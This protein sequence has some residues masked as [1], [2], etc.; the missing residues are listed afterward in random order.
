MTASVPAITWPINF[1]LQSGNPLCQGIASSA[2]LDSAQLIQGD[3]RLLQIYFLLAAATQGGAATNVQL[4]AG[5]TLTVAGKLA[6]DLEATTILFEATGFT[7]LQDANSLYFD[8]AFLDLDTDEIA[9]AFTAA[10]DGQNT[11]ACLVDIIVNVPAQAAA[12]GL[13]A[14]PAS[15][16]TFQFAV[17][18]KHQVYSGDESTPTPATPTYPAA[19]AVATA[20]AQA[21]A[22]ATAIAALGTAASADTGTAAGDVVALQNVGGVAKLPAVDGSQL[23]NLPGSGSSI[24]LYP[25]LTGLILTGYSSGNV[26]FTQAAAPYGGQATYLLGGSP[27]TVQ[28]ASFAYGAYSENYIVDGTAMTSDSGPSFTLDS[29]AGLTIQNFAAATYLGLSVSEGPWTVFGGVSGN[30]FSITGCPLLSYIYA[31][32]N[33]A[34]VPVTYDP[35]TLGLIIQAAAANAQAA[36]TA[37]SAQGLDG[38]LDVTGCGTPPT[39]SATSAALAALSTLGW[40]VAHD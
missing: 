12:G 24:G 23:T 3:Q 19:A 18:L 36:N 9:A 25:G 5:A 13:P 7:Q 35:M 32:N 6:S 21:A 17:N 34:G 31:S 29:L 38:T 39:D 30:V 8:Q 28:Y 1:A 22:A 16:A 4:P 33:G 2:A 26:Y 27:S 10:G 37:N 15:R 11:L 14:V 20:V 40:T